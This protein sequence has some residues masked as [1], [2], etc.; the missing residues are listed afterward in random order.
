[1]AVQQQFAG[2][3][4]GDLAPEVQSRCLRLLNDAL[5]P[6]L[7]ERVYVAGLS[8][9]PA[10]STKPD[11]MTEDAFFQACCEGWDHTAQKHAILEALR[12]FFCDQLEPTM[13]D[14]SKAI[15]QDTWQCLDSLSNRWVNDM[16][17]RRSLPETVCQALYRIHVCYHGF[18]LFDKWRA[19]TTLFRQLYQLALTKHLVP[20]GHVR[21]LKN[22][23]LLFKM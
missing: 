2:M 17:G 8:S 20:L 23:Y 5:S 18:V 15:P 1:M 22:S 16:V 10:P 21:A 9:D 13:A 3:A 7:I 4:S 14:L 12:F 6:P 11:W 19:K